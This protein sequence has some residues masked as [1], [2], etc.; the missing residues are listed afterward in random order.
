VFTPS[1]GFPADVNRRERLP[2]HS[3]SSVAFWRSR[4]FAGANLSPL[5]TPARISPRFIVLTWFCPVVFGFLVSVH[6]SSF[7]P[8][9][10]RYI[11]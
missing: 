4:A 1:C 11:F 7:E 8:V 9:D 2:A 3:V 10:S 6:V 5:R